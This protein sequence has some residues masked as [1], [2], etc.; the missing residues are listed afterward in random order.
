LA[1]PYRAAAAWLVHLYTAAGALLAFLSLR[2]VVEG[3]VRMA[4]V[5]LAVATAVDSTDGVLARL[6]QVKTFASGLDGA[7]LDDIVDYL[8]YVFIPTFIVY[9]MEM[10]PGVLVWPVA[11]AVL[12]SSA[13]GFTLEDAKTEDYFF[14]GFPSYWNVVVLYMVS[15]GSDPLLNAVTLLALS[16]LVFVRIGYVYP[17][18]TPMW[19]T[20]T[21]ALGVLWAM[22]M[23]VVVWT[24]PAPPRPL[25][26]ASLVFPVYYVVLSLMLQRRRRA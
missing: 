1:R 22:A 4:F 23:L 24:L 18:R 26:I 15:L 21:L 5:W 7:R 20:A 13:F 10:V 6:A 19:R 12:L 11:A 17:S 8:T 3:D 14:T 9:R 16:A 25:V 2:E